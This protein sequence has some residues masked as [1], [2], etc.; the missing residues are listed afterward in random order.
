MSE[1]K[2][3]TQ[4]PITLQDLEA[5]LIEIRIERAAKIIEMLSNKRVELETKDNTEIDT[6]EKELQELKD[7]LSSANSVVQ[8]VVEEKI[9]SLEREIETLKEYTV[10]TVD[11]HIAVI[12]ERLALLKIYG[13]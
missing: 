6:K 2:D 1:D 12:R 4:Q 8:K 10:E 3:N 7:S 5:K 13:L 11:K 9:Q